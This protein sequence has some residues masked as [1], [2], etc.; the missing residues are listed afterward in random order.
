MWATYLEYLEIVQLLLEAGAD[1]NI[2]DKVSNSDIKY[3]MSTIAYWLS[4]SYRYCC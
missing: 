2:K 1:I 3:S 4:C